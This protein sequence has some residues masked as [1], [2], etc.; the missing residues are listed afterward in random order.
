M[1]RLHLHA[2]LRRPHAKVVRAKVA[3][4]LVQRLVVRLVPRL[5][6]Q[7]E[8]V[9][10][11][12]VEALCG[13]A[14]ARR[15]RG[16]AQPST[17]RAAHG[18]AERHALERLHVGHD[19]RVD[20]LLHLAAERRERRGRGGRGARGRVE[21]GARR[22]A[23]CRG[24]RHVRWE[25]AGACTVAGARGGVRRDEVRL[26]AEAVEL[27]Q[28]G[29]RAVLL[30]HA[31]RRVVRLALQLQHDLLYAQCLFRRRKCSMTMRNAPNYAQPWVLC[32]RT[33]G[34]VRRVYQA[35]AMMRVQRRMSAR[36]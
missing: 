12:E 27:A 2:R 11:V 5:D 30:L 21:R 9:R 8:R 29:A 1:H 14:Q 4:D 6:R 36:V 17:T 18:A 33:A 31:R 22:G 34:R 26:A 16:H 25:H 3:R 23:R 35:R 28:R 19:N 15:A 32:R 10:E 13:R 20:V 7:R 24:R